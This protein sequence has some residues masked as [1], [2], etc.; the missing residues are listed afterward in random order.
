MRD[1]NTWIHLNAYY[2]KPSSPDLQPPIQNLPAHP[3]L[4]EKL[5]AMVLR[6]LLVLLRSDRGLALREV[7][8]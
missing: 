1:A 7:L 4:D 8:E 6:R 3:S 5:A 2:A